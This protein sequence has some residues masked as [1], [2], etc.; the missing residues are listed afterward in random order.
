VHCTKADIVSV[1]SFDRAARS[2]HT[3][4]KAEP[5]P[6]SAADVLR[7]RAVRGASGALPPE[8]PV[9]YGDVTDAEFAAEKKK[10]GNWLM[11][12]AR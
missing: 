7:L 4:A 12:D 1:A 8:K 3:T 5:D 6:I 2:R 11:T 9:K 10:L